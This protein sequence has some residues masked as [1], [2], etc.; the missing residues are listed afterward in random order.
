MLFV[1]D[2]R[3]VEEIDHFYAVREHNGIP[4]EYLQEDPEL[5]TATQLAACDRDIRFLTGKQLN[6][7]DACCA[8]NNGHDACLSYILKLLPEDSD[9]CDDWN[10]TP[11]HWAAKEGHGA[12]L[13]ILHTA[14]FSLDT[15][16]SLNMTPVWDAA[17]NGHVQ[18]LRIL[19]DAGCDMFPDGAGETPLDFFLD[20]QESSS[21]DDKDVISY[22]MSISQ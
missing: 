1:A 8:A 17:R 14:G 15:E 9:D 3:T 2:D 4:W 6:I 10:R 16:D 18:C 20:G 11:A 13:R 22:F 5:I 21:E 7:R 19:H 12:C